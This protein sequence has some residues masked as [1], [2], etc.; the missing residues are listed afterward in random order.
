MKTAIVLS[1]LL[2]AASAGRASAQG[3]GSSGHPEFNLEIIA[4]PSCPSQPLADTS[5]RVIFL[6]ADFSDQP[7][8]RKRADVNAV[9]KIN[10]V[11]GAFQVA[12]G[13]A[14]DGNGASLRLP[15]NPY[16]CPAASAAC[17][18]PSFQ[19]YN[20]MARLVGKPGSAIKIGTCAFAAGDDGVMGTGDDL[21][22]CS[23]ENH[24]EVRTAGQGR[25]HDVTKE[26]TTV[27]ADVDGDG[28]LDRA[29]LFDPRLQDYFW[30]V[31]AQGQ[32]HAQVF[33][34]AV[35]K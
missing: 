24:V 5:R 4:K 11:E 14:C 18:D 29:S 34:V 35:G 27:S 22:T 15:A 1:A 12:D 6:Q 8:G 28:V 19:K 33:F 26:L 17:D 32:A 10:L 2:A 23:A 7:G 16:V 25:F 9:N 20:V 21:A 3:I 13:N 30:S 31:D